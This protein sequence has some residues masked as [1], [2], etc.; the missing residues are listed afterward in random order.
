MS[1]VFCDALL[2]SYKIDCQSFLQCT[3]I[4]VTFILV[5]TVIACI[6]SARQAVTGRQIRST[7]PQTSKQ[8]NPRWPYLAAFRKQNAE[9]KAKQEANYD[10]HYRVRNLLPIPDDTEVWVTT[11]T[12]SEPVYTWHREEYGWGTTIIQCSIRRYTS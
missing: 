8:L 6:G 7:V 4:V 10:A 5:A 1:V 3:I 2:A 12:S 9:Y 11:G